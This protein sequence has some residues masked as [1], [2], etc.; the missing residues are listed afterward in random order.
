[1]I[2]VLIWGVG[3]QYNVLRNTISYYEERGQI[4][5]EA[6]VEN[7]RIH[8]KVD[9]YDVITA[10]KIQDYDYDLI[11]IMA[12]NSFEEIICEATSTYSIDRRKII[13]YRVLYIPDLDFEAYIR[14]KN[15]SLTI[16]SNNCW[17][18]IVYRTLGME[19]I[20]PFRN[21]FLLDWDYIKLISDFNNYMTYTPVGSYMAINSHSNKEYPVLN[22]AD[23]EIHCNHSKDYEEAISDWEKRK[24]RINQ[25]NL[26]FEMYTEDVSVHAEFVNA[27]KNNK[28]VCFVN[29]PAS[30]GKTIQLE[31]PE[32]MELWDIVNKSASLHGFGVKYSI[33]D[34]LLGDIKTRY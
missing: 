21:L 23:I 8:S 32:G 2:K 5:I 15:S 9:G 11:I 24:R 31:V 18:G 1:M 34:L 7:R 28:A 12:N 4:H 3:Y 22:I 30:D 26:F 6:L 16:V 29:W 27:M 10:D 20:S 25:S 33:V 17:G 19:C 14:L 13:P